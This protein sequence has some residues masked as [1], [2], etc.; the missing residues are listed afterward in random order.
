M[1]SL[2]LEKL[3]L[4]AVELHACARGQRGQALAEY[5][6]ILTVVAVGVGIP[7]MLFFRNELVSVYDSVSTCLSGGC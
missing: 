7:T 1:R 5:A 6:L 2:L 3:T 4:L